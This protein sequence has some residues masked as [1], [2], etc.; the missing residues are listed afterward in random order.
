MIDVIH[1]C[2]FFAVA[3]FFFDSAE[4]SLQ[5]CSLSLQAL[6]LYISNFEQFLVGI[7]I[8]QFCLFLF[9]FRKTSFSS[10]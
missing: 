2:F 3:V 5:N 9:E 8:L 10:V 1:F 7:Y 4:F 6:N